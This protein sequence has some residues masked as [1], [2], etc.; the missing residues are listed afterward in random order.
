MLQ[1]SQPYVNTGQGRWPGAACV[2]SIS[3]PALGRRAVVRGPAHD[4]CRMEPKGSSV[5]LDPDNC[6]C[7]WLKKGA[8]QEP[9]CSETRPLETVHDAPDGPFREAQRRQ[10]WLFQQPQKH[11]ALRCGRL[12]ALGFRN[13]TAWM[14]REPRPRFMNHPGQTTFPCR[15]ASH[16]GLFPTDC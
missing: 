9:R 5:G 14:I 13:A 3:L 7:K 6:Q 12:S 8:V 2:P 16:R 10:T 11:C 4:H 15:N 1:H